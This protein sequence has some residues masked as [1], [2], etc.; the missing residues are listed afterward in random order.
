MPETQYWL[1][2][3][4]GLKLQ[5]PVQVLEVCGGHEHGDSLRDPH[6]QLPAAIHLIPGPGCP[7]CVC[8]E[9]DILAAIS[10]ARMPGVILLVFADM[11]N[12]EIAVAPG[13]YTSLAKAR[14]AGAEVRAAV[15]RDAVAIASANPSR[16]VVFFVTGFETTA[17]GIAALLAAGLPENLKLLLS[18]RRTWPAVAAM[19]KSGTAAFEGVIAPGEVAA[20]MGAEEWRFVVEDYAMPLAVAGFKTAMVLQALYSVLRQIIDERP[21]LDNCFPQLASLAGDRPARARISRQFD[22][23]DSLWRGIGVIEKSGFSLKPRF[24]AHDARQML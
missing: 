16:T 5:R 7:G 24:A 10:L 21:F 4:H 1:S 17:A 12:V 9:E 23:T 22:E 6:G 13:E 3:I 20:M 18:M 19:L 8:P 14:A 2:H 11:L 15:P